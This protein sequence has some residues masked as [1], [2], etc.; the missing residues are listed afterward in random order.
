VDDFDEFNVSVP[1][2]SDPA[3][4]SVGISAAVGTYTGVTASAIDEDATNNGVTY[5]IL[6]ST[7]EFSVGA[8]GS[9]NVAAALNPAGGPTRLVTVEATS[10]DGSTSQETFTINVTGSGLI[11]TG[12]PNRD[13]LSGSAQDDQID[14][15][16]GNDDLF[17]LG[18][19]DTLVGGE[20]NDRLDGGTG[21]DTMTGGNGNDT[22]TVDSA[23][24]VVTET[25]TGGVNDIVNRSATIAALF[26]NVEKLFLT[27]SDNI[28]GSGNELSN[29]ID[30][31]SGNNTLSGEDGND[32]LNGLDGA[33]TLYGGQGS[34]TLS[35]DAGADT[36]NGGLGKDNLTG[37]TGADKFVFDLAP[38]G[39][40]TDKIF[41]FSHADGDKIVFSA[42]A[43]PAIGP[44][45]EADEL[46][47]GT[48]ANAATNRVIYDQATGRLWYD[49]DGNGS[50]GPILV[51]TLQ[52]Q[53]ALGVDDFE[54]VA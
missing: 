6:A 29:R 42:S 23:G 25:S 28:D 54:I 51:A 50:S 13:I 45:L 36:L 5:A 33:D 44:T 7:G 32:T 3:S 8:D 1:V 38:S 22:Y 48:S 10:A 15:L 31:N 30:G 17:G 18:G 20:G 19:A 4:N 39:A 46:R 37:G 26:A 24:D 43:F 12:T 11:L 52:N 21:D 34:D 35:G 2:D 9:I 53:A 14:G 40:D 47:L 27:G 49:A 41:D 16:G